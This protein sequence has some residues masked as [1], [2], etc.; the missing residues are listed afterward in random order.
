MADSAPSSLPAESRGLFTLPG[1]CGVIVLVVALYYEF[2][3]PFGALVL[4][5]ALIEIGGSVLLLA[6]W[7]LWFLMAFRSGIGAWFW[8][9]G[10]F[11]CVLTVW[12]VSYY[13]LS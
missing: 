4:K 5:D 12:A 8:L 1:V 2:E 9:V 10:I 3:E 7:V 6:L 13:V 11:W